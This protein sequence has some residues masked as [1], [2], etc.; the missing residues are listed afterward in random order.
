MGNPE[1]LQQQIRFHLSTLGETNGHHRFESLCTELV[2]KRIVSN[3]MPATGPV[4]AKGDQ[5]R[6]AESFWSILIPES[7]GR[8][9]TSFARL[10]TPEKVVIA[11][12]LQKEDIAKKVASDLAT[13]AS[14][15]DPVDRVIYFA[16][17]GLSTGWRHQAQADALEQHNIKLDVWDA[18]AISTALSEWDT[19]EIAA[20]YLAVSTTL[21][22]DKPS[23]NTDLPDWYRADLSRW[24]AP[25][26]NPRSLGDLVDITPGLRIASVDKA[27][28]QDLNRW[29]GIAERLIAHTPSPDVSLNAKYEVVWATVRGKGTV[30]E[31]GHH[32]RDVLEAVLASNFAD[33]FL[34]DKASL[35]LDVA[36]GSLLDGV[37]AFERQEIEEWHTALIVRVDLLL[38]LDPTPSIRATLLACASRLNLHQVYPDPLPIDGDR[39]NPADIA[40]LRH[41]T[42]EDPWRDW[43][44][45]PDFMFRD[46]DIGMSN[47]CELARL[48][49][50][51]P[52]FPVAG[53][54]DVFN[55]FAT[56]LSGHPDYKTIRDAL[57][58]AIERVEGHTARAKRSVKRGSQFLATGDL[59]GALHEVH[60][61]KVNLWNGDT[62]GSAIEML[63]TAA[64]IYLRLNLPIAAK[65]YALAAAIAAQSSSDH[66]IRLAIA[67]GLSVAAEAEHAAGQSASSMKTM[68]I[69][70]LAQSNYSDDP[71]N[72]DRHP[73][74]QGMLSTQIQIY[75]LAV[76]C[77][78]TLLPMIENSLS[79]T[80]FLEIAK[81]EIT[82]LDAVDTYSDADVRTHADADRYG[83]PFSDLGPLR[84]YEW[85]ALGISWRVRT[86]NTK[87]DVLAA[88][89]TMSALQ[90]AAAE[91][92]TRDAHLLSA[93][94]N[95]EVVADLPPGSSPLTSITTRIERGQSWR[96][97]HVTADPKDV[98]GVDIE[99]VSVVM[100]VL[101]EQSLLSQ[102]DFSEL[103]D[104]L[105][106]G[107]L[108][109]KT[110]VGRPYQELAAYL[111]SGA[112][113]ALRDR[114][115]KAIGQRPGTRAWS[116]AGS[117]LPALTNDASSYA[118]KREAILLNIAYRYDT[119]P[120]LLNHTLPQLSTDPNFAATAQKLR[121]EG[122]KDWHLLVAVAGIAMNA[123]ARSRGIFTS[124]VTP[125][126]ARR[127]RG[128]YDEPESATELI[129][130]SSAYSEDE[131]RLHLGLAASSGVATNGMSIDLTPV[132]QDE[133][134][135]FLGS[136]YH[137][138]S[139]DVPHD[140][141]VGLHG[142]D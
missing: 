71:W 5:G 14:K 2:R 100:H 131:L 66:S 51:A 99:T 93:P 81:T 59:L 77:R 130:P 113:D 27:L 64:D 119:I 7:P 74:V 116:V 57:D 122:W 75:K 120:K 96:Q 46:L 76:D 9:L 50:H 63:L 110:L 4:S 58:D 135:E 109:H 20:T 79:K 127:F 1:A 114:A 97:I 92:G 8:I 52:L 134:I 117:H 142:N 86:R 95:I 62:I 43:V 136:R 138:W 123:R 115:E 42:G 10:V 80:G 11:C 53:T 126:V 44:V 3:I 35:L 33:P 6:D 38:E 28:R 47:L 87:T 13:I 54:A 23:A 69:A 36:Y 31:A 84:T 45:P 107:G 40:A 49:P 21:A 70:A 106:A 68:E 26:S 103:M 91:L 90:V 73:Y 105:G 72:S 60:E 102:E 85:T 132:P 89:R 56:A 24:A 111:P 29:I 61:A 65:H 17:G 34:L 88:E 78:P 55:F 141:I 37:R 32:L 108:F 137:Y 101:F 30:I 19:F 94:I 133:L 104:D 128:L 18:L 83:L 118:N 22:P 67:N 39:L 125:A 15:G 82:E 121:E 124:T 139:D 16:A 12:T 98:N 48:L 112:Y 41:D 25:E 129:E 140:T